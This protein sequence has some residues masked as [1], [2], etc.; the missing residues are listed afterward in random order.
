MKKNDRKSQGIVLGLLYALCDKVFAVFRSGK[1]CGF[2]TSHKSDK[3][4]LESSAL[5][6]G[7][8]LT[9]N[10]CRKTDEAI[11]KFIARQFERSFL[12]KCFSTALIRLV[13]ISGRVFGAFGL[14]WGAY[15]VLID[16]IKRY[17]LNYLNENSTNLIVGAVAFIA[18]L[19]LLFSEKS[20]YSLAKDSCFISALLYK[21]FGIPD[22]SIKPSEKKNPGQ[23]VAVILGILLGLATYFISPLDIILVVTSIIVLLLV[24]SY[25][26]GGVLISI[27][28]SPLLGLIEKSSIVLAAFVLITVFS[29]FLKVLRG[30]R[31]FKVG[32]TGMSVYAFLLVILVSGF[33]PG[34]ADTLQN[35]LL[36]CSLMLIFPLIVNLMTHKRWINAC[37]IAF[38]F[39]SAIVAFVG[40]AQYAFGLSPSGW[41]DFSLFPSITQRTV[42][43]FNNPNILGVYL[44]AMFPMSLMLTTSRFDRKIRILGLISSSY[45]VI[46]TIFTY[47][48]SAWIALF[49]GALFFLVSLS[50]R[51]ILSLIPIALG[52]VVI[53]F[54]FPDTFGVRLINLFSVSDSANSYRMDIW[55]SSWSL[56]SDTF[57]YGIGW[58]EEAFKTAY[59]N[60]STSGAQYAMH[61][62]SLYMQIAIQTG[63]VGLVVF[64]F[65]VLTIMRK[66]F[67]V[68]LSQKSNQSLSVNSLA[69]ISGA[70]AIMVAG[71]FD[72]TWYNFRVFFV[73]WALLAFACAASNI[74][75][76]D[77]D[78]LIAEE[79]SNYS[80]ITVSIPSASDIHTDNQ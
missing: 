9:S 74:N 51:G 58:G 30:K 65:T 13:S 28:I 48:R 66:C 24:L 39:P 63:L 31:V 72:Y 75:K 38:V 44:S 18:S 50:P 21:V 15:V 19:P 34:D 53:A 46:A 78:L 60:Y 11:K 4:A 49:V 54:A 52:T 29:Y 64:G 68:S 67:S 71:I 42:S 62:H 14:T 57:L 22:E 5:Y 79:D 35:A 7:F 33:T 73:F 47:S 70:V 69:S 27:A 80:F 1:I 2:L 17:A 43:I 20:I 25:P 3:D 10:K 37:F 56:I 16:L 59:V 61:S 55:N 12:I 40:I 36:C 26:E 6:R 8:R 76:I 41:I 45:I 23:S 77:D 32:I